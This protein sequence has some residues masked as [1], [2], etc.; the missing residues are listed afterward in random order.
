MKPNRQARTLQHVKFSDGRQVEP[1]IVR[2]GYF[3]PTPKLV[4]LAWQYLATAQTMLE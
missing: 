1:I 4:T 3:H 2:L